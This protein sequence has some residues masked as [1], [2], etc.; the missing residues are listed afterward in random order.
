[1]NTRN[2]KASE[3]NARGRVISRCTR[4]KLMVTAMVSTN[5]TTFSE[6]GIH[7]R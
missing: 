4:G 2:D 3:R 7:A 6:L 1:M 5:A